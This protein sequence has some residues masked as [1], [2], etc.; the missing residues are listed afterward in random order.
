LAIGI[1]TNKDRANVPLLLTGAVAM[2]VAVLLIGPL[3]IRMLAAAGS[4]LPIAAR[5]ALRDLSR[6]R[7]RSASALAAIG[8]GLGI[9]VAIIVIAAAAE[10]GA[11]EG[12]LSNRQ[13]VVRAADEFMPT[14]APTAAEVA[15]RRDEVDRI[16][17][18]VKPK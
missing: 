10:H 7:A 1:D 15:D 4:R 17:R 18:A 12:N 2:V 6:Y 5:L 8:V 3:A 14:P 16:R 9:A 11:A 13:L